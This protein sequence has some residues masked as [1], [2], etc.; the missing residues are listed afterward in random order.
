MPR[1]SSLQS[2]DPIRQQLGRVRRRHNLHETQ[3]GLYLVVGTLGMASTAVVLLALWGSAWGFAAGG[4]AAAGVAMLS[5][6][7]IARSVRRGLLGAARSA[8]WADR[9]AELEGRLVTLVEIG[10]R[11]PGPQEA[12]FWPLLLQENLQRLGSWRPERLVP[13]RLPRG[14]LAT[15]LGAALALGTTLGLAP[16]LRP[17]PLAVGYLTE[18]A[19]RLAP[20]D[21][22]PD[23]VLLAP[24]QGGS[25]ASSEPGEAS[26]GPR[27]G[28]GP[29]S[30]LARLQQRIREQVWGPAREPPGA[31]SRSVEARA[32]R[33]AR[34]AHATS[35]ADTATDAGG[36]R[37]PARASASSELGVA[38]AARAAR[39][40]QR[41]NREGREARGQASLTERGKRADGEPESTGTDGAAAGAGTATAPDLFGRPTTLRTGE[42]GTFE[43]ALA[44]PGSGVT[45]TPAPPEGEP[46]PAAADERPTLAAGQWS[47]KPLTKMPVPAA[48]EPFVRRLFAHRADGEPR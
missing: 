10:C 28:G 1:R 20:M 41:A 24:A 13:R 4:A 22:T 47:E 2:L 43:L 11:D 25:P 32:G 5:V 17:A 37:I 18:P 12:F 34:D 21:L 44:A 38:E 27:A 6:V 35:D 40:A 46:P 29:S 19:G 30:L 15:A 48:Y 31:A 36:E 16:R 23:R 7:F 33:P 45:P 3:R 14:A 39:L 8:A 26:G 9:Q 42:G